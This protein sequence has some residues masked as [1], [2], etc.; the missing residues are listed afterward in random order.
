MLVST[1]ASLFRDGLQ[2]FSGLAIE[3]LWKDKTYNVVEIDFSEIKNISGIRDF[4]KQ[5][6]DTL[7]DAFEPAGFCY[8]KN[9]PQSVIKQISRWMK[10]LPKNS[11][12]LLIDEY[13]SP[14]TACL[15]DPKLFT[16]VRTRLSSFYA[17]VKANDK[18]LRFVFMTGIAKVNQTGIFS[19]LNNFTDISLDPLYGALLGYTDEDIE[20]YFSGYLQ[21]AA[22]SLKISPVEV[23]AQLRESYDGYCFDDEVTQHL[24]APGLSSVM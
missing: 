6:N 17:A 4:Y 2:Y 9:K 24:Y 20:R 14:M 13:D 7:I 23:H 15:H 19:E 22:G 12:V 8:D 18:C 16:S 21:R 10:S 11:L 1:F 3:K 5:L